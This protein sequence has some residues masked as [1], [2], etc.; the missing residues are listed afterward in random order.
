MSG[1]FPVF[2]AAAGHLIARLVPR[3]ALD[4]GA[5]SGKYG[6][7]LAQHAPGCERVAVEINAGSV[8]RF[9]L[10]GLYQRV[11]VVDAARW[12]RDNMEEAFDLAIIGDCL[13]SMAKSEGLDLLNALVYR[14]AWLLVVVP[15]FVVQGA[16]DGTP[17]SVH[18]SAW[19]ERDLHWHDLWAWDN[20][21]S[22]SLALLRGYLP[23]G[24]PLEDVV[25]DFNAAHV[26]LMHFDGKAVV[27][28]GRL[29]LVD[30]V[31]EVAYRP[32]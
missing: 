16:V 7:L 27:R 17:G 9:A 30:H 18:R 29:R 12:W 31:R 10:R 24:V 6:H 2:D 4:I 13:Q 25:R 20:V 23:A 22:V 21:R 15:E 11:D 14:C 26:P 5:G 19:S 8:E 3:R 28:P 1:S 32:R